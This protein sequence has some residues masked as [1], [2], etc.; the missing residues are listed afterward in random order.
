[1]QAR[2]VRADQDGQVYAIVRRGYLIEK[3]QGLHFDLRVADRI[4]VK[5]KTNNPYLIY[6]GKV[7]KGA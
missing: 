3:L 6:Q 4:E 5:R 1:M 2:V 7:T